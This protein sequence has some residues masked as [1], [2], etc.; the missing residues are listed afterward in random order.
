MYLRI[1]FL[2]CRDN[3]YV[4]PTEMHPRTNTANKIPFIVHKPSSASS[5]G[6][7]IRPIKLSTVFYVKT[8]PLKAFKASSE[9]LI[10]C[11]AYITPCYSLEND[12]YLDYRMLS[13]DS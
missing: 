9:L 12:I 6:Y 10:I 13:N 3:R 1:L 8:F 7:T 4:M 5:P 11:D 2:N